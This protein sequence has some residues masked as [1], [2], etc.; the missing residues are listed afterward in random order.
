MAYIV[1]AN[2]CLPCD[3]GDCP[4]I[5]QDSETGLVGIQGSVTPGA[6]E[7]HISW[8]SSATLRHLIGQLPG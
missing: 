7:E 6:E 2:S 1:L 5:V 4:K 8:M 3:D